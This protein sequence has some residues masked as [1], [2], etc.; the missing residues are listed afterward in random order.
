MWMII[1]L[2]L[3][4]LQSTVNLISKYTVNHEFFLSYE[5]PWQTLSFAHIA[6][7]N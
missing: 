7:A 5:T 6:A 2:A 3:I 4:L 1:M